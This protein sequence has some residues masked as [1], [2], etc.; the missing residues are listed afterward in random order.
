MTA[1]NLFTLIFLLTLAASLLMQWWL[2]NRHIGHIKQNRAE[3]PAEFS[4]HITLADHQKAA[5]YTTSKVALGRYEAAYGALI[6]LWFTLG[7]L[8]NHINDFWLQLDWST[9]VTGVAVMMSIMMAGSLLDLPFTLYRTF[10]TEQ[11]F[12]FNRTTP[13]VFI[14]DMLKG[15]LLGVLIGGPLIWVILWLMGNSGPLW[16]L[17]A[18]MVWF[19]FSLFMMWAYPA[20]IAPLFNKFEALE[21]GE[22][23][24]RIEALL[25]QCGFISKGIYVMDGSRRSA[26]GNAYFSGIGNNKRIVFYDTLI[27]QLNGDEIEAVL[28]HE[29]GHFRM[30]HIRKRLLSMAIIGLGSLALLGWLIDQSWFYQGLG[31]ETA[32]TYMGLTLF[33]LLSPVF[34]FFTTPLMSWFSRKH[35]FE[36]DTYAAQ[37]RDARDLIKALVKMYQENASTLTPDPLYS[38]FY[39]SHPPAP[40]RVNHLQKLQHT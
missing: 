39:D 25:Q 21:D 8:M 34:G 20:F 14:V 13:A 36:A 12:G 11:R 37:Q 10:V 26:H 17:Y 35:E 2:A 19:G 4:E 5:D 38:S 30:H 29:L 15:A 23:K 40:V 24:S 1:D 9:T 7:G 18:W 16:W 22:L 33:M 6:L 32:S 27:E 31:V 3:V 28:A